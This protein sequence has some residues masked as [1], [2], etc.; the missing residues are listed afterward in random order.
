M[1]SPSTPE[2]NPLSAALK[3]EKFQHG[4]YLK[5]GLG[6]MIGQASAGRSTRHFDQ[7][8][9]TEAQCYCP[10]KSGKSC[11]ADIEAEAAPLTSFQANAVER[12]IYR[13]R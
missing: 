3:N 11:T 12:M 4:H 10:I 2:E 5:P 13:K 9:L 8:L 1:A 6:N 7:L